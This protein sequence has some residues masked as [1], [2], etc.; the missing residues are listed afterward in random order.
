MPVRTVRVTLNSW[1]RPGLLG[2]PQSSKTRGLHR[3]A[4]LEVQERQPGQKTQKTQMILPL[5]PW[6]MLSPERG[7]VRRRAHLLASSA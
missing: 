1:P 2:L 7:N 6:E 3:C 4:C 5:A